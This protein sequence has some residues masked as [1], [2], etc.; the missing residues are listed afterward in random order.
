MVIC[1]VR[2]KDTCNV[3]LSSSVV[4]V[5]V[6]VDAA[7]CCL[8]TVQQLQQWTDSSVL[9]WS[10]QSLLLEMAK[11]QVSSFLRDTE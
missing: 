4:V 9:P 8:A 11:V 2:S 1:K 3:G 6:G 7:Q 10:L 5:V